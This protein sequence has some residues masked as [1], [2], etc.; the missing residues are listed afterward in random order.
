MSA[1]VVISAVKDEQRHVETTLQSMLAQTILPMRWVI[2]DDGSC[3]LTPEI[4]Q[5]YAARCPWISLLRL[6]REGTRQPGSP[7][8]RAFNAGFELVRQDRFEFVVKLD[9]DLRLPPTYFEELL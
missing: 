9:C 2:V 3:D 5:S 4:V 6:A 8:V 7:V 1:Y